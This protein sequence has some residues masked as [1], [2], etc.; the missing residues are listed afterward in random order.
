MTDI[1]N[2]FNLEPIT[3]TQKDAVERLNESKKKISAFVRN[4]YSIGLSL[5][6]FL[7]LYFTPLGAPLF[8]KI[9]LDVFASA[10]GVLF[11]ANIMLSTTWRDKGKMKGKENSVYIENLNKNN[12]ISN[13]ITP[14]EI[15][16]LDTRCNELT[17][18]IQKADRERLLKDVKISY[19]IY[20]QEYL[21][22]DKK[23]IKMLAKKETGAL[24]KAQVKG[25][26]RANKIKQEKLNIDMLV[27]LNPSTKRRR[28]KLRPSER[29]LDANFYT[30]K[31]ISKIIY[32]ALFALISKD[33]LDGGFSTAELGWY[34]LVCAQLIY[35][36]IQAYLS[37]YNG[38]TVEVVGRM[39][40]QR[41]LLKAIGVNTE[42]DKTPAL[43]EAEKANN[44][45]VTQ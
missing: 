4:S 37:G 27:K 2:E 15:P 24:S 18:R 33:L 16:N 32:T 29:Q 40:D 22:K 28:I 14:A 10:F 19:D 5:I 34:L 36:S 20:E 35:C 45:E 23:Y 39:E 21:G 6:V 11:I 44:K 3:E 30:K 8:N 38:M 42:W 1:D 25:I 41:V 12:M 26:I 9:T 43:G 31:V 17:E 7:A 13:S